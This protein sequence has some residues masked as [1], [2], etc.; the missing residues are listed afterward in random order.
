[1]TSETSRYKGWKRWVE[2]NPHWPEDKYGF[3]ENL[4]DVGDYVETYPM[5]QADAHR[6][7]YAAHQWA[8]R[9]DVRVRVERFRASEDT[10]YCRVFLTA[11]VRIRDYK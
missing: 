3:T 9:H 7:R 5:P 11:K 4:R 2:E 10:W 8:Y 6:L 1:M